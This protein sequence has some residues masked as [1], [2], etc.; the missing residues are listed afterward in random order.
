MYSV[1]RGHVA[2]KAYREE[3]ERMRREEEERKEK[4]R[5]LQR[6]KSYYHL[7]R[8]LDNSEDNCCTF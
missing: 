6:C 1:F 8:I 4:E 2:R 3:K 7:E 5:L